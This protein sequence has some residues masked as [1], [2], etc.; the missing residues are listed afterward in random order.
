MELGDLFSGLLY[1]LNISW[2]GRTQDPE[3]KLFS[4]GMSWKNSGW[5]TLRLIGSWFQWGHFQ[6]V[7]E[8]FDL[9]VLEIKKRHWHEF[10]VG[11]GVNLAPVKIKL[12]NC[13]SS[14]VSGSFRSDTRVPQY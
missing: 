13:G 2:L 7:A 10:S 5:I 14:C 3:N 8:W 12:S 4:Q 1:F 6:F 11:S 9:F